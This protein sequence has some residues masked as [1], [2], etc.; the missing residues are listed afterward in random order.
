MDRRAYLMDMRKNGLLKGLK[1][2]FVSLKLNGGKIYNEGSADFIMSLKN[3][4]LHFQKLSF[5]FRNL[6][7]KDDFD[8]HAGRF[9]EYRL[10]TSKNFLNTLDFYDK[11]GNYLEIIYAKGREDTLSTEDNIVRIIKELEES[12]NLKEAK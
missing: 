4:V 5:L 7:P 11:D 12:F 9:I 3:G 8:V 1:P 10:D 6:K 2:C